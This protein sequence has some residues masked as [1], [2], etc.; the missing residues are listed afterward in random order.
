[1]AF[2]YV[3]EVLAEKIAHQHWR[4]YSWDIVIG[5]LDFEAFGFGIVGLVA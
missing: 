4:N 1:L 3:P 5:S 2:C